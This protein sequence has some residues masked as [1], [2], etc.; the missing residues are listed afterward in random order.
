MND[1]ETS[2]LDQRVEAR[3]TIQELQERAQSNGS[4]KGDVWNDDR[5]SSTNLDSENA[6]RQPDPTVNPDQFDDYEKVSYVK[7]V[8]AVENVVDQAK[9]SPDI[10]STLFDEADIL[11]EVSGPIHNAEKITKDV[12][13]RVSGGDK[14]LEEIFTEVIDDITTQM[15]KRYSPADYDDLAIQAVK[16]AEPILQLSLIHI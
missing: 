12:I 3:G 5:Y 8:N 11:K 7:E 1:V 16:R 9:K 14:N 2:N 15:S 6:G 10:Q 4:A 13:E